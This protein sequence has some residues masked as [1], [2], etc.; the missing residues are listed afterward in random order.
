MC[1][2]L[3]TVCQWKVCLLSL[4]LNPPE[5]L[6]DG[7]KWDIHSCLT[8]SMMLSLWSVTMQYVSRECFQHLV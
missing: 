5:H 1:E 2:F 8:C 7:V 4:E 6:W 3:N